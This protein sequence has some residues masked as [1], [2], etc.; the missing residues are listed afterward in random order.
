MNEDHNS[1]LSATVDKLLNES[2]ERLQLHL[3]ERVQA[4]EEKSVMAQEL[5]RI[6]QTMD[7]ME[8]DR[9]NINVNNLV[10]NVHFASINDAK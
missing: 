9:V 7:D 8:R 2:N 6:R 4:M 5:I 1:R 10:K 3:K